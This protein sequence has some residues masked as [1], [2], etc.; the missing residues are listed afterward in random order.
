MIIKLKKSQAQEPFSFSFIGSN[1][2][3]L[4]KS[5]NYKTKSSALN[6]IESVRKNS[7]LNQRCEPKLAKDGRCYFNIKASN[8]QV[9]GTSAM[10]ANE[11]QRTAAI[12]ELKTN[13]TQAPLE[14]A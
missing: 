9:V 12:E 2:K 8:G 11:E 1:G 14:E 13:A 10:F 6:G 7:Q 3:A 4:I 5:E